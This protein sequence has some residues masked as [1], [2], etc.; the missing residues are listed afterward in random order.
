MVGADLRVANLGSGSRRTQGN[1]DYSQTEKA[2]DKILLHGVSYTDHVWPA[3]PGHPDARE[4]S[5]RGGGLRPKRY[6]V[7]LEQKGEIYSDRAN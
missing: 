1:R 3:W 5:L 2:H 4:C 7:G 6:Q